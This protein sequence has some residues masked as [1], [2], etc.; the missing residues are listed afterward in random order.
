MLAT[1]GLRPKNVSGEHGA[2]II[3]L[4]SIRIL[5][6]I[7]IRGYVSLATDAVKNSVTLS[8]HRVLIGFGVASFYTVVAL[9]AIN[10]SRFWRKH[11]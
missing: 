4:L 2:R 1:Q 3:L 6:A 11:D 9:L 8:K 5:D 7:R 10:N